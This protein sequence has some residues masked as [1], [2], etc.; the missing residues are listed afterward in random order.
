MKHLL[1][2][3]ASAVLFLNTLAVPNVARADGPGGTN[4]GGGI[5]KP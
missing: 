1:L 4:C 3:L 2:I 5:C